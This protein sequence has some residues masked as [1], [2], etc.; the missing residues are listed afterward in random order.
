MLPVPAFIIISCW[1][2]FLGYWLISALT[3]KATAER[4]SFAS[5]LSYRIPLIIGGYLLAA[6]RHPYL[7]QQV[8][9]HTV[10]TP[11]IGAVVCL[12]GLG[13]A[14]WSRW[15][16]GGNWS[17]DVTFKQNH[18]LV[19]TGPYRFVRH[20][21]YTGILVMVLGTAIA[22]GLLRCWLGLLVMSAGLWIKLKQEEALMLRH[23]PDTYPAYQKQVKALIPYV[24]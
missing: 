4:Q 14:I 15:T 5:S 8:T 1:L 3:V 7:S 9:S 17:S 10:A 2:A 6:F 18:E 16:L 13:V 20:P 21:I 24:I 19:K 12:A 23:F 22:I 11:W